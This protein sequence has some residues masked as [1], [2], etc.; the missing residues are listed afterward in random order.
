MKILVLIFF[1]IPVISLGQGVR[2]N[3]EENDLTGWLP[4]EEGH[5]CISSESALEGN[6]SLKHCYNNDLAGIDWISFFHTPFLLKD[7]TA[8]WQ[9]DLR[10][11]FT[12]SGNNHWAI[13]LTDN[14][15]PD[16]IGNI[17]DGLIL[18]V[19]YEGNSDELMIWYRREGVLTEL[20]NTGFN[21]QENISKEMKVRFWLSKDISG[22]FLLQIDTAN[23]NWIPLGEFNTS[24]LATYNAFTLFY[25]YTA[26]YDQ[27][28][29][30]DN[31]LIEGLFNPDTSPPAVKSVYVLSPLLIEIEFDEL[32]LQSQEDDWCVDGVGCGSSSNQITSIL[33][34]ELPNPLVPGNDYILHIPEIED[35]YSNKIPGADRQINFYYPRAYDIVINEVMA[36]PNPTVLLPDAEYTELYNTSNKELTIK[37]WKLTVNNKRIQLPALNIQPDE[38]LL[39]ADF[40]W[41]DSFITTIQKCGIENFPALNNTGAQIILCDASGRLIHS[42]N[43]FDD[44]HHDTEKKQGGWSLEIIDPNKPCIISQNWSSSEDYRGG[45]PGERNSVFEV[46]NI[47]STP[48]LWRAAITEENK[49][50]LYFSEPLDSFSSRSVDYYFV[51]KG[52]GH[53]TGINESWPLVSNIEL[54][55]EEEFSKNEVYEINL[56]SD[57]C[58]CSGISLAYPG[59]K[60]FRIPGAADSAAILIN[61]ILF[62]PE[63]DHTEFIELYNNSAHTIDL[64]N[65]RFVAGDPEDSTGVITGEYW[66]L[67]AG[68][69]AL[70]ARDYYGIDEPEIFSESAKIICMPDMPRLTNDGTL[71][72]LYTNIGTISDIAEYSPDSHHEILI[73]SE[74]VSLERRSPDRS[75]M[76]RE[77]WHSASSDAGYMTPAAPNSQSEELEVNCTVEINPES[78]TPNRGGINESLEIHYQLDESGY[79]G[80]IFIFDIQGRRKRKLVDGILLG[81]EG[82]L[83]FDGRGEDGLLLSTGYYI[84][85]FNAYHENGKRFTKKLSFVVAV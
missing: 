47:G 7:A 20:L 25:K 30:L 22:K 65:F 48:E 35:I 69:Y 44:W 36:D 24:S 14:N 50:M 51:D 26:T 64:K 4:S 21:W 2:V 74:G 61:E 54:S 80:Q 40:D 43:Y 59:S 9:F 29:W 73:E 76:D 81:T 45:T 12:P 58:N 68:D 75:G 66:P 13:F 34:L 46:E 28:L 19:N 37:D 31:I 55:F 56:T 78:I 6:N 82:I 27:G 83:E 42:V 63:P 39:L 17:K 33:K 72:Y 77:T 62:D 57:V 16:D 70:L 84:L 5:W 71:L 18:G 15:L 38:Y 60:T 8:S 85:F 53:P 11:S 49:L 52:I 1:S 23:S 10:Y 67:D 79:M 32:V 41:V 3:F